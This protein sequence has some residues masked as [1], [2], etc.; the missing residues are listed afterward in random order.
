MKLLLIGAGNMGEA[1]LGGLSRYDLSVVVRD[2]ERRESLKKRYPSITFLDKSPNIEGYILI[3][4]IKPS[5]LE[6][7]DLNGTASGLISILAGTSLKSLKNKIKAKYYVRAMPNM[8]ALKQ[9]SVTSLCGDEKLKAQAMDILQ[10]IGTCFWLK[11]EDELNIAMALA[12]CAPAWLALVAEALSDGAVN[13]GLKRELSYEMIQGLFEGFGAS[14]DGLHPAVLKD[15]VTSPKGT[16]IAGY[17]ALEK[18]GVRNAF[19]EALEEA[20]KRT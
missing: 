4:A 17:K 18:N 10:S 14:L 9:K 20:Y 5:S 8:A 15:K 12:G 2:E 7:L 11:S 3:L 13:L 6:E 1:I 19:L 16:T